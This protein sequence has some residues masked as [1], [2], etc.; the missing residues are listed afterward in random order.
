MHATSKLSIAAEELPELIGTGGRAPPV[1]H[2]QEKGPRARCRMPAIQQPPSCPLHA[3]A[4]E[5]RRCPGA[6]VSRPCEICCGPSACPSISAAKQ[7]EDGSGGPHYRK[8]PRKQRCRLH[9]R[10]LAQ[11]GEGQDAKAMRI[12][13]GRWGSAPDNG[14]E[15]PHCESPVT[16]QKEGQW[17]QLSAPWAWKPRLH[18]LTR[19]S[20]AN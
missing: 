8:A 12:P 11:L 13:G 9:C 1:E 3:P 5:R 16:D 10:T 18:G 17:V 6:L 7:K 20:Q 19:K 15:K 14:T 2:N 4:V